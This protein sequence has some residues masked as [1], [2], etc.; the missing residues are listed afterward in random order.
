MPNH[1][2]AIIVIRETPGVAVET[3]HRG[4]SVKTKWRARSLGAIINQ[5]KSI[6]TKRIRASGCMDFAWQRRFYDHIIRNEKELENIGAYI[7][8]NPIKWAEDEYF[9]E[10]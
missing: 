9:S 1:I 2:H 10:I 6:C 3:P 5:F 8:G 4:V 7:L